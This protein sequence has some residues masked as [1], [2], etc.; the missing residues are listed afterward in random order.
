MI[1]KIYRD[2]TYTTLATFATN[3]CLIQS[4][5]ISSFLKKNRIFLSGDISSQKL[6]KK[7]R[8]APS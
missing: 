8:I 4:I 7:I 6:S 5:D 1:S 2:I 3:I